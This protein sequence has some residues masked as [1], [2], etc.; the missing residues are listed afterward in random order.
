M[1]YFI[2]L[3]YLGKNY[4]GWQIQPNA[5]SVQVAIETALFTILR[6]KIDITGCGRTD[7]GVHAKQYFAHFDVE[8]EPPSSFLPRVNK[9]LPQDISIYRLIAVESEAHTRFDAF[10]RAYE[11]HIEGRKNPFTQDTA[12]FIYNFKDLDREKMQTAA[13]ILLN[14]QEFAPFCKSDHDAK[15]LICTLYRSEWIWDDENH[16]AVY[17]IAA[18]RFLRGM[19][20]LIVGMCLNVGAGKISL[21]EVEN[22]LEQQ[23]LL[24]KS[25][26]AE[27]Q[28]LFLTD[29]KYPYL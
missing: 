11:Y 27:P 23:I 18:N 1:R 24:S 9:I 15:T 13:K 4:N 17:H 14:Y 20:R 21:V 12:T 8:N 7:T 26:S 5:P 16:R 10:H 29:I 2:E 28:G 25:S 3:S 6:E 22:A 19:V